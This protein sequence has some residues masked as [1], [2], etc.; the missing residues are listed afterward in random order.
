MARPA[1]LLCLCP[2]S[3]LLQDRLEVL[4]ASHPPEGGGG[5][6]RHVFWGDEGIAPSFWDHL[7]LQGLLAVP[8]ALIFRRFQALPAPDMQRLSKA[9]APLAGGRSPALTW[10]LLCLEVEY[11][12]GRPKLPSALLRLPLYEAAREKNWLDLTPGLTPRTLAGYIRKEA[13]S[14]GLALAGEEIGLLARGL[15]PDAAAVR[16][17]LAR[18][19]LLADAQGRLPPGAAA[20]AAGGTPEMGI[21]DLLRAVRQGENPAAVWRWAREE[22]GD[23]PLFALIALL[24]REA[25]SL[26]Q[27]ACP[28]ASGGGQTTPPGAARLAVLWDLA[29]QADKGVKT[30]E[31]S[32][33]QALDFLLAELFLFF[34][35]GAPGKESSRP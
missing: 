25:R 12:R 7:T 6:Q 21:F 24:L 3:G 1:F 9:L 32:P 17:E 28:P 18:L 33:E 35:G 14:R 15:S 30:G 4:M 19:S 2:D 16:S 29:L 10:P 22:R 20:T 5:W 13:A 26:W 23:P 27:G 31:R 11:E 8:K 34:Q